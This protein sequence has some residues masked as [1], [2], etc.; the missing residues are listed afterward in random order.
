MFGR[1]PDYCLKN[2]EING[3]LYPAID[4]EHGKEIEQLRREREWLFDECVGLCFASGKD[5]HTEH[6]E[7][8]LLCKM[9]QALKEE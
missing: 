9:R 3:K 8:R 5:K 1:E 7:K 4:T 2:E 6:A